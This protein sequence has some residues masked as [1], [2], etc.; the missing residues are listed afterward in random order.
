MITRRLSGTQLA[1]NFPQ[2]SFSWKTLYTLPSEMS[3][4]S[5]YVS[6]MRLSSLIRALLTHTVIRCGRG[7]GIRIAACRQHLSCRYRKQCTTATLISVKLHQLITPPPTGDE[8]PL[9]RH[10][11]RAKTESH[12]V[13]PTFGHFCSRPAI[14]ILTAGRSDTLTMRTCDCMTTHTLHVS[15]TW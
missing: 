7:S 2:S 15:T 14:L 5:G 1:H 10:T 11:W 8:L 13:L 4:F 6:L 12:C 9:V 3:S